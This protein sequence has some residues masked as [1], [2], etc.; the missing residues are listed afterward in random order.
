MKTSQGSNGD[1][2]CGD[3]GTSQPCA[4]CVPGGIVAAVFNYHVDCV[5]ALLAAGG[6]I[7]EADSN[8]R[9]AVSVLGEPCVT[10]D[11]VH[12]ILD[13]GVNLRQ[14]TRYGGRPL[15]D[16]ITSHAYDHRDEILDAI[17]AAGAD[18]HQRNDDGDTILHAVCAGGELWCL[19]RLIEAGAEIDAHDSDNATPFMLALESDGVTE[20][21]DGALDFFI[22]LVY[23]GAD[24]H[25]NPFGCQSAVE[26]AS[27]NWGP[28]GGPSLECFLLRAYRVLAAYACARVLIASAR[29]S[30]TIGCVSHRVLSDYRHSAHI[31]ARVVL[32]LHRVVSRY[33][34]D[35]P[36]SR[37]FEN[38]SRLAITGVPGGDGAW[39]ARV[40]KTLMHAGLDGH[41]PRITY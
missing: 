23:A 30:P 16:V 28:V 40:R 41:R 15:F 12:A 38:L 3:A 4:K 5:R 34:Y 39:D 22:H 14:P 6:D 18:V 10:M 1:G 29:A 26:W 32:P 17:L 8:G 37:A 25:R 36:S 21:H 19:E 11:I 33:S 27:E 31:V 20:E 7:N 9:R 2:H 24:I 35:V 13:A